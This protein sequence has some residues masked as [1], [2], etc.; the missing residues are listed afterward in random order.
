MGALI[1]LWFPVTGQ[2]WVKGEC[3][4]SGPRQD[5]SDAVSGRILFTCLVFEQVSASVLL[6]DGFHS[7]LP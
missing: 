6:F 2:R 1:M 5:Q 7:Q 3:R 4:A